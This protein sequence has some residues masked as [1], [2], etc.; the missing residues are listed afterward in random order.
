MDI[1]AGCIFEIIVVFSANST[2]TGSDLFTAQLTRVKA[3]ATGRAL[4]MN[5]G[6]RLAKGG[7]LAFLHADVIPPSTYFNDIDSTIRQGFKAGFF[8]YR[9]DSVNLLLRINASF[10]A[11]DGIFTG[12][13]DQCL[14]IDSNTFRQMNGF[15]ESQVLME[16]F[17]FFSR[18][19]KKGIPY[20]IVKNDLI[21]SARKY[22]HNSYA[23][24]NL[25][26]LLLL[27]LFK[28]GYPAKKLKVLHNRLIRM[29]Y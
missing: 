10:T 23:R 2:T 26:N 7:I 28:I 9:F 19:K 8:S 4:Q 20:T 15:D 27:L 12:G 3:G 16:D 17:E 13:G 29:P 6:A 18:M 14:F 11:R 21:V 22:N 5:Y 25:S 24:I 1:G